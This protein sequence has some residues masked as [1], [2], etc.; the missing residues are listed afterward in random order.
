MHYAN[1]KEMGNKRYRKNDN[2]HRHIFKKRKRKRKVKEKK[3][4]E[5]EHRNNDTEENKTLSIKGSRIINMEQ[6]QRYTE[7][8]RR[9]SIQCEGSITLTGEIREGLA[10]VL[11]GS[12]SSCQHTITFQTSKK[13]KGPKGYRRCVGRK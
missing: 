12:C 7:D 3:R 13:V 6:L 10:S 5:E 8:L 1:K 11:T 4:S 2:A 9:H